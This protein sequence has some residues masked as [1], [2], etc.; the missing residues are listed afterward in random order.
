M[1]KVLTV[2]V[3]LNS[4]GNEYEYKLGIILT[5]HL[6]RL[7]LVSHHNEAHVFYL[8]SVNRSVVSLS[9]HVTQDAKPVA[10]I[11]PRAHDGLRV[12]IALG[13]LQQVRPLLHGPAWSYWK[14]A[15]TDGYWTVSRAIG[16][17]YTWAL[18]VLRHESEV[19]HYQN[20][21]QEDCNCAVLLA[22]SCEPSFGLDD[23][24]RCFPKQRV[25]WLE[26]TDNSS[27]SQ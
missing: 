21:D 2:A 23:D 5:K 18:T 25:E 12:K 13:P 15:R 10:I 7:R 22:H 20:K 14:T 26:D 8:R 6:Q 17:R 4:D 11:P 24:S 16:S 19:R 1:S 9:C 27:C 3:L